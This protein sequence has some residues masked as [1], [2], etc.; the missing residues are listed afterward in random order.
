MRV[1]R[2]GE[3][4]WFQSFYL[5]YWKTTTTKRKYQLNV[6]FSVFQV[7]VSH[8]KVLFYSNI[9]VTG[10]RDHETWIVVLIWSYFASV[11]EGVTQNSD[12]I[13]F[14]YKEK[15]MSMDYIFY[16]MSTYLN[17]NNDFLTSFDVSLSSNWVMSHKSNS[18]YPWH[19][20]INPAGS[21]LFGTS[22]PTYKQ[23]PSQRSGSS[24]MIWKIIKVVDTFSYL[25]TLCTFQIYANFKRD[26]HRE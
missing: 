16:K 24:F 5:F 23:N 4:R 18:V 9:L 12:P 13:F 7:T 6:L 14:I 19:L 2:K 25:K 15:S 17:V 21:P 3:R 10:W 20:H 8:S 26:R 11:L 22:T 1:R